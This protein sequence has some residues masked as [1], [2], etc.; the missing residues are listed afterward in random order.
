[1]DLINVTGTAALA[2]SES[3]PSAPAVKRRVFW[4]WEAGSLGHPLVS[5]CSHGLAVSA[6]SA[7]QRQLHCTSGSQGTGLF[8]VTVYCL[9]TARAEK[10]PGS[11]PVPLFGPAQQWGGEQACQGSSGWSFVQHSD[12]A[13]SWEGETHGVGIKWGCPCLTLIFQQVK[14]RHESGEG[15]A[16]QLCPL[17]ASCISRWSTP[18]MCLLVSWM[19]STMLWGLLPGVW[20]VLLCFVVVWFSFPW[21]LESPGVLEIS[22]CTLPLLFGEESTL[23]TFILFLRGEQM[24]YLVTFDELFSWVCLICHP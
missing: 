20:T 2:H 12:L 15:E 19:P 16:Q 9:L 5:S 6:L 4:I 3:L 13:A 18:G 22:F 10:I 8:E 1:M 7:P 11:S 21:N 24:W 23:C 17:P 14:I